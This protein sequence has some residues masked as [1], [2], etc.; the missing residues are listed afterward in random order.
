MKTIAL[1]NYIG[2][3]F[4]HNEAA[5][6][7]SIKPTTYAK[8]LTRPNT[9]AYHSYMRILSGHAIN[10]LRTEAAEEPTK[11]ESFPALITAIQLATRRSRRAGMVH[12][13]R[14]DST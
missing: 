5:E 12:H 13:A 2:L 3:V 8:A 1:H 7:L 4:S 6:L 9:P 14:P 10:A 11:N